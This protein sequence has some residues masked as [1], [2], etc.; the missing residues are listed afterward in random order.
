MLARILTVNWQAS[1]T[2]ISL[3]YKT[4]PGITP[5]ALTATQAAAL[6]GFN[7]NVYA[8]YDIG[9]SLSGTP[10]LQYGICPSGNYIDEVIGAAA[11]AGT[12][13]T[14]VFNALYGTSTKIPQTD[15]G[16]GQIEGQIVLALQQFVKNG[17]LGPNVWDGPSFGNLAYGQYLPKGWYVYQPSVSSQT[18]AQRASRASVPFQ[19]AAVQAG[20]INTANIQINVAY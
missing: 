20:A 14:N 2:A 17:F 4:E 19:V 11:L 6:K 18:P 5:E 3:M 12:I 9:T 10:I 7:C 8:S 13:Q 15:L 1:N 16:Q